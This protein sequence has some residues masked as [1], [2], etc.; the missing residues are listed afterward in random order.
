MASRATLWAAVE[1]KQRASVGTFD[2][3]DPNPSDWLIGAVKEG[4]PWIDDAS[5]SIRTRR[6][7]SPPG[8]A[9]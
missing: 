9:G 2:F 5:T 8:A 1:Q 4:P 7:R 6:P 3:V